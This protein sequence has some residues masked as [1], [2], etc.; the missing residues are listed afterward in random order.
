HV[1]PPRARGRR[2]GAAADLS[3]HD[4]AGGA[5]RLD[6]GAEG[7]RAAVGTDRQGQDRGDRSVNVPDAGTVTEIVGDLVFSCRNLSVELPHQ[8][9]ARRVLDDI[10]LELSRGEFLTVVGPSGTGKTTLLR[11][12]G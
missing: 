10:S 2:E 4:Q 1:S 7:P 9:G 5:R 8:D 12:L 3:L 6:R 11:V